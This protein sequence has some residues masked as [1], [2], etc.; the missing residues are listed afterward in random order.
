MSKISSAFR[1]LHSIVSTVCDY[2]VHQL[3][4]NSNTEHRVYAL[5]QVT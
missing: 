4:F 3:E 2:H 5:Q 1:E